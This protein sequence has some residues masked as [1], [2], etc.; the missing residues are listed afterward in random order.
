MI[1]NS[2]TSTQRGLRRSRRSGFVARSLLLMSPLWAMTYKT[3]AARELM[4]RLA[5]PQ[6]DDSNCLP[7]PADVSNALSPDFRRHVLA[8][9]VP[10]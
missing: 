3:Q 5:V 1:I 10:R 8:A 6:F 4:N 7:G 2:Y 9:A